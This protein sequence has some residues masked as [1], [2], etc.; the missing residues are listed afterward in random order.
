MRRKGWWSFHTSA[1]DASG[2]FFRWAPDSGCRERLDCHVVSPDVYHPP[3]K[4]KDVRRHGHIEG[5]KASSDAMGGVD[6]LRQRFTPIASQKST[7]VRVLLLLLV[8]IWRIAGFINSS[9]FRRARLSAPA[10]TCCCWPR[11]GSVAPDAPTDGSAAAGPSGGGC[12]GQ[13]CPRSTSDACCD[14]GLVRGCVRRSP[15]ARKVY[16]GIFLLKYVDCFQLLLQLCRGFL[17]MIISLTTCR[18][19]SSSFEFASDLGL[20]DMGLPFQPSGSPCMLSSSVG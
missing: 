9:S 13:R 2:V 3:V 19:L 5:M 11:T 10:I 6:R 4:N 15:K 12:P 8:L 18:S 14:L 1:P 20:L 7:R 17:R 16:D